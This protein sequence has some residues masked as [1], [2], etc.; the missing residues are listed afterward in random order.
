MLSRFVRIQLVIFTIASVIGV[1]VMVFA[2]MQVPTLLGVGKIAVTLELPASGGLYR[3]SNVTYRGVQVGKVTDMGVSRHQ[4]TATLTLDTSPKIPADLVAEVR[5]VSAIGEQYVELLPRTDSPPYLQDGSV[6][7]MRDTKIPQQVSPMLDE[8]STLINSIPKDKLSGLIDESFNAFNESGYDLGSLIDSSS[9]IAGDLN[10]VADRSTTLI[11]DS[12]PL[13]D[14]QAQTTDALRV[15]GAELG[16]DHGPGGGQRPAGT[17]TSAA[18]TWCCRRGLATAHPDQTDPADIAGEPHHLRPGGAD[19]PPLARTGAGVASAV[20]GQ[21]SVLGSREQ[22]DGH[23][24]GGLPNFDRGSQPVHGRIP[25]A[26]AMAQP[27]RPDHDRHAGRHLLQTAAG[28]AGSCAWRAQRAL[29]G[30]ARQ[31]RADGAAVL[32]R[33][34]VRAAGHEAARPR[35]GADRSELDRARCPAR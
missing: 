18:G 19:L 1:L 35:P 32:Q 16:R 24:A 5:S 26:V 14:S 7:S 13:L 2:Y 4:A 23:P 25:A 34:T 6:I 11:E 30:C 15:V 21:R 20:R 8:V 12:G 31:A 10:R 22:P 33:Q 9:T 3:F 27:G 28:F 29:H 17:D